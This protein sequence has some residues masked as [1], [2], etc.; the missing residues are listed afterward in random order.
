MMNAGQECMSGKAQAKE[1]AAKMR[2]LE[3][4]RLFGI[5]IRTSK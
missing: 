4:F 3:L 2:T 1:H 5:K